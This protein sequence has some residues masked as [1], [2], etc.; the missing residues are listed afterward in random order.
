[1]TSMSDSQVAFV[2]N[3]GNPTPKTLYAYIDH[4]PRVGETIAVHHKDNSEER[5]VVLGIQHELTYSNS[6]KSWFGVSIVQLGLSGL[7]EA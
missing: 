1:M 4:L 3:D 5:Y 2:L 6:L 7:Q